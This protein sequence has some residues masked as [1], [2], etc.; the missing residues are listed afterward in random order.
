MIEFKRHSVRL[1]HLNVRT[2]KRGE[3]DFPM[4]DLK[5]TA[6]LPN[7]ALDKLCD[8]LRPSLYRP[9][10]DGDL[11]GKDDQHMPVLRYPALLPLRWSGE[12]KAARL[13]MHLGA[14]KADDLVI[15]DAKLGKIIIKPLEGGTFSYGF[16]L[17]HE[18]MNG[19]VSKLM[20]LLKHEVPA[21]L[22]LSKASMITDETTSEG[23]S[24]GNENE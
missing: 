8:G 1:E 23:A 7:T 5:L 14:R 17:Q 22:D 11:L 12:V 18:P 10:G 21:T 16:R 3:E 15:G 13:V 4:I 2:E 9:D 20:Q 19:E 6:D 24:E